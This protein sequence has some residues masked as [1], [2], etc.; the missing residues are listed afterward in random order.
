[1]MMLEAIWR[2]AT[3]IS[4]AA[5]LAFGLAA[6]AAGT[7]RAAEAP[8]VIV[9][10]GDS[11]TVGFHLPQNKS[12]AAQLDNALKAR[13]INA[14]VENAGVSGDTAAAG[15][16]RVDWS[17]PADADAVILELGANDALR[18]VDPAQTERALDEILA[19]FK[20]RGLDVL[21]AGM[22]APRN[23][24]KEYVDAFQTMYP[25]LAQKYDALFYPFF[26]EGVAL[27]PELSL[28][29]GMHPNEKGVEIIAE[30]ILPQ[31]EALIAR[32][33]ARRKPL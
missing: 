14:R 27:K 26:L 22:E 13:G 9:A 29:D 25:R 19:K 18:G 8:I 21:V 4:I 3:K 2:Q 28:P 16:A 24:G 1:M 17:M 15:L 10:F 12:F 7:V 33:K 5:V 23:L 30:N 32:V 20:A 11:L 6:G 31:V